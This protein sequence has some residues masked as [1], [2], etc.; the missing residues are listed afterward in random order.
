ML[1]FVLGRSGYGKSEY[2]RRRFADLAQ[3]GEDKLLFLVPDQ[4]SF[5]TEAAFLESTVRLCL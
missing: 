2:L 5:E 3:R 1:R 4:I